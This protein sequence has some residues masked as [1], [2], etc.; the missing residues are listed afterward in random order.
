MLSLGMDQILAN[1]RVAMSQVAEER[2]LRPEN[3]LEAEG[4]DKT[5]PIPISKLSSRTGAAPYD[6]TVVIMLME[7]VVGLL[8]RAISCNEHCNVSKWRVVAAFPGM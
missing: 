4:G 6:I 5:T 7:V 8:V 1:N 2:K 3:N